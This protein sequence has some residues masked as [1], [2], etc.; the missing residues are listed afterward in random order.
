MKRGNDGGRIGMWAA[1]I[2]LLMAMTMMVWGQSPVAVRGP[3]DGTRAVISGAASGTAAAEAMSAK[4]ALMTTSQTLEGRQVWGY[5][6][7][8]AE[9]SQKGIRGGTVGRGGSGTGGS[10]SDGQWVQSNS[11]LVW[12]TGV[13]SF[14]AATY[15]DGMSVH[16]GGVGVTLRPTNGAGVSGELEEGVVNYRGAFA[17]TDVGQYATATTSEGMMK[18]E[19][20]N[21]PRVYTWEVTTEGV[22]QVVVE[23]G[24]IQFL[25]GQGKGIE[26]SAPQVRG[27]AE[28]E[29]SGV[30]HWGLGA[31]DANGKRQLS[32]EVSS[33][34]SYP[35]TI[36]HNW[37]VVQS[38]PVTS[39]QKGPRS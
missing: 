25:D 13:G 14:F 3:Q 18:V 6:T 2:L 20:E 33:G 5:G 17:G 9:A 28:Q 12:V 23:G 31:A 37:S 35:L 19:N 15:S 24:S 22:A 39:A 30:A 26:L 29:L 34:Q 21:S 36:A 10:G 16:S 7:G 11:G 38:M 32:L 4:A 8:T 1:G 27:A